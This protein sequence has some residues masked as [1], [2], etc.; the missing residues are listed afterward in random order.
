MISHINFGTK[1]GRLSA[2]NHV[3]EGSIMG[4]YYKNYDY[5]ELDDIT[6]YP[7]NSKQ[8]LSYSAFADVSRCY[9]GKYQ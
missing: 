7:Y 8:I 9:L 4:D 1:I 2:I 5:E 6:N 3:Y